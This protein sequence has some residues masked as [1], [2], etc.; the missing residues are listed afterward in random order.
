MGGTPKDSKFQNSEYEARYEVHL[1]GPK[2]YESQH[3]S[4]LAFRRGDCRLDIN[5]VSYRR[6]RV[7]D[8]ILFYS[9]KTIDF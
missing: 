3:F 4:F 7:T 9:N 8:G 5:F 1:V 6:Q 2:D